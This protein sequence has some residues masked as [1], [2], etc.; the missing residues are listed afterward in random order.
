MLLL[1]LH[2]E[3]GG[4]ECAFAVRKYTLTRNLIMSAG[5]L[6]NSHT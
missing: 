1:P 3:A 5:E 2:R 4:G 6:L